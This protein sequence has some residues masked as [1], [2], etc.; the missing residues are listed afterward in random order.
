MVR[1]QTFEYALG[2]GRPQATEHVSGCVGGSRGCFS[3]FRGEALMDDAVMNKYT[4][5]PN[6]AR[7]HV[8]CDLGKTVQHLSSP[9]LFINVSSN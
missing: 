4:T 8:Q 6:E 7:H 1:N 9:D 2:P 5:V 3:L